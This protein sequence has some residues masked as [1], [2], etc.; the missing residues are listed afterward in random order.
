MRRQ[1]VKVMCGIAATNR[2]CAKRRSGEFRSI[3]YLYGLSFIDP[4]T[5]LTE[6]QKQSVSGDEIFTERARWESLARY[7]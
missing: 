1:T 7:R 3:I 5:A 4:R 6:R 2:N